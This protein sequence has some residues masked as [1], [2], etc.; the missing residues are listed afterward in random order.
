MAV[1][2]FFFN[3]RFFKNLKESSFSLFDGSGGW[4]CG[5]GGAGA[6]CDHRLRVAYLTP[7]ALPC[8]ADDPRRQRSIP[9]FSKETAVPVFGQRGSSAQ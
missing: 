8:H 1:S 9:G 6:R 5:G 2:N 3:D 4:E 7:W